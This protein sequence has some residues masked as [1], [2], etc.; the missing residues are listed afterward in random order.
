MSSLPLVNCNPCADCPPLPGVLPNCPDSE[1]CDELSLLGCV[2]VNGD[3]IVEFGIN[4][5]DRLDGILQKIIVAQ[6]SGIQCVSPTVKCITSL[7]STVVKSDYI[8]LAWTTPAD[9]LSA[10]LMYKTEA[11]LSWTSVTVTGLSLK[12]VTGLSASTKYLFKIATV[13]SG[14]TNCTSVTIAVTTKAS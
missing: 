2:K 1:P 11:A 7:R 5:G 3:S 10:I 14:D 4:T 9:N 13:A 6:V 12:E 8:T